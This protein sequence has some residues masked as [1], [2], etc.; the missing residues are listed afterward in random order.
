[1]KN[2]K[3][4]ICLLILPLI[5]AGCELPMGWG[6]NLNR[7][8]EDGQVLRMTEPRMDARLDP[9]YLSEI[10]GLN[11]LNNVTEPLMRMGKEHRPVPGMAED[12]QVS[13]DGKIYTFKIRN[14]AKWSD[15]KAVTAHDFA[16]AWKRLLE[17]KHKSSFASVLYGIKNAYLYQQGKVSQDVV[18]IKVVDDLTLQVKLSKPDKNFLSK[19]ALPILAPQRQDIIEKYNEQYATSS[20][21]MVYNGPFVMITFTPSK[22][23]L[24][25]NNTYWDRSNVSLKMV[26]IHVM[27]DPEKEKE[28]YNQGQLDVAR[29]HDDPEGFQQS[30]EYVH[31]EMAQTHYLFMNLNKPFFQ[32]E[33][34]RKAISLAIDRRVIV[35]RLKDGSKVAEGMVPP[36]LI[37]SEG[38]TYRNVSL[39]SLVSYNP[40]KAKKYLANG[41]RE[42]DERPP[43]LRFLVPD[44]KRKKV[45]IEIKKQLQENLGL[46]ILLET[47][48]P[49]KLE[50]L[51]QTGQY[52]FMLDSWTAD[53]NDP[54]TFLE[55]LSSKTGRDL[56]QQSS[57]LTNLVELSQKTTDEEKRLTYL[58]RIEKLL[59]DP[60][61]L[62]IVIPLY[63]Q[64]ETFLQRSNIKDFIRHPFGAEYS[65]KWAYIS[66]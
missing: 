36:E 63:Y 65:L 56:I 16:Y 43:S 3:Y 26:E 54:G 30:S 17:P 7:G 62:A 24:M 61:Q 49:E 14:D 37:T 1:M 20:N 25:K 10:N 58:T 27:K 29:I 32:N 13:E 45:A 18:G 51:K 38:Q 60:D 8:L 21:T 47:P 11:V 9:V 28:L 57:V 6:A 48:E 35:R 34:I 41:L 19:V 31:T 33:H 22:I 44:D 5:L 42:L 52:D 4:W 55:L 53:I 15:G 64:G 40:E 2:I 46:D 50:S 12:V 59:I 39:K 23:V 66:K